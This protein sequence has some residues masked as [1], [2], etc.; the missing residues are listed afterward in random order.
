MKERKVQSSVRRLFGGYNKLLAYM[1]EPY[2]VYQ[3]RV[4]RVAI[5]P[6]GWVQNSFD[7][8][9]VIRT[10]L[11]LE[12]KLGEPPELEQLFKKLLHF[13]YFGY[14]G[15][16]KLRNVFKCELSDI[17]NG[18]IQEDEDSG[19]MRDITDRPPHLMKKEFGDKDWSNFL[20][21]LREKEC[22]RF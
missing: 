14:D 1:G 6:E 13:G 19:E 3:K 9:H 22:R 21:F 17:R 12:E 2:R 10:Y 5:I 20:K 7:Q 11:K 8:A 15:Y 16:R 18:V 4:K